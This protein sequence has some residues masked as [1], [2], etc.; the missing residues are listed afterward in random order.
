MLRTLV[1]SR[2]ALTTCDLVPEESGNWLEGRK[3]CSPPPAPEEAQ[4]SLGEAFQQ[5]RPLIWLSG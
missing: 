2:A 1:S 5:R 4:A 3:G